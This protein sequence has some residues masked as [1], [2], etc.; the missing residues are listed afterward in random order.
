[1]PGKPTWRHFS[2]RRTQ[3]I[4]D[5]TGSYR[6][7][8][9]PRRNIMQPLTEQADLIARVAY[10]AS[11]EA[12]AIERHPQVV[13]VLTGIA[14]DQGDELYVAFGSNGH[15]PVAFVG[16][17]AEGLAPFRSQPLD[18]ESELVAGLGLVGGTLRRYAAN[19]NGNGTV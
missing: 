12:D 1:M 2:S 11:E 13:D 19:G 18:D 16:A 14:R 9:L 7:R 8:A 5:R 3:V 15:D 10:E 17:L 4:D 6:R